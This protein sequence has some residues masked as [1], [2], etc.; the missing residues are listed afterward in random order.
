MVFDWDLPGLA[1]DDRGDGKRQCDTDVLDRYIFLS[2]SVSPD[3]LG[4]VFQ[5]LPPV[6][7]SY[8]DTLW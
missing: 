7:V 6:I 8:L 3:I 5:I 2:L 1:E 4:S